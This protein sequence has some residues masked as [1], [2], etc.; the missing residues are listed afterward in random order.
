M[1]RADEEG[2]KRLQPGPA[3]TINS[4]HVEIARLPSRVEHG[5]A[6]T[7]AAARRPPLPA[8]VARSGECRRR[9]SSPNPSCI[10]A[11]VPLNAFCGVLGC[12]QAHPEPT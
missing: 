3:H 10:A 4:D 7:A 6:V 12:M 9:D 2:Q 1:L 11:C 8:A 5:P